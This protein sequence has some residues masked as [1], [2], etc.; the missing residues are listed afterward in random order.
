MTKRANDN[1]VQNCPTHGQQQQAITCS[2][3]KL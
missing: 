2:R 3:W 1:V